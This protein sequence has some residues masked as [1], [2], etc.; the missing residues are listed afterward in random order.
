MLSAIDDL[1]FFKAALSSF[2]YDG[3]FICFRL[4]VYCLGCAR[5]KTR[6]ERGLSYC[7][8]LTCRF[9]VRLV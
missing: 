7:A 4:R 1:L 5:L 9:V 6:R 2:C 8:C 3:E